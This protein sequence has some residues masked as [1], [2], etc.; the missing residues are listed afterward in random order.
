MPK[1]KIIMENWR[2]FTEDALDFYDPSPGSDMQKMLAAMKKMPT[3]SMPLHVRGFKDFVLGR[4]EKWTE[5]DMS[6]DE[7]DALRTAAL[8]VG[9][10]RT[11]RKRT[12]NYRLWRQL[13]K[14]KLGK[15]YKAFSYKQQRQRR[16]KG[17]TFVPL[18]QDTG[19]FEP[20][21]F[22]SLSRFLGTATVQRKG[23]DLVFIDH[24]D[25]NDASKKNSFSALWDDIKSAFSDDSYSI[26]RRMAPW[27]QSTGYEGY[28]V[29]IKIPLKA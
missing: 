18:K 2:L 28:P 12:V 21:H 19:L 5:K 20:E 3:V 15:S 22:N 10:H 25:F 4:T 6:G 8:A 27:R 23:N 7:I 1:M 17:Q 26:A 11:K 13:S 9:A 29:E 24:Y 14:G 16:Q